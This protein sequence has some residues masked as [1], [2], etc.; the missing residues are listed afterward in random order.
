[1]SKFVPSHNVFSRTSSSRLFLCIYFPEWS[2]DVTRRKLAATTSPD[3]SAS[4]KTTGDSKTSAKIPI[5]LTTTTM[6]Q[7]VVARACKYSQRLGVRE[8]MSLSLARALVPS[9][10]YYEQFDPVRDAHALRTLAVW[11]LRFSPIVGLDNEIS[12]RILTPSRHPELA[13]VTAIHYGIIIDITGTQRVN[14]D[15]ETLCSKL[16]SLLSGTARIAIAPSLGGAWALS[17][18]SVSTPS[19]ALS[20]ESLTALSATLPVRA[21]RIDLAT[22]DKLSDVGVYTIGDLARLPRSSLGHRFGKALLCRLAQLSGTVSEQIQVVTPALQY[23]EHATFEPPLTHRRAIIRALEQLFTRLITELAHAHS[24]AA[25]FKI[26]ISDT[27][28]ASTGATVQKALALASATS[29]PSHLQAIIYPII[30]SMRFCG[31][32]RSV[33][34]E[35]LDTTRLSQAQHSFCGEESQ[36]P[37][38]RN[39]AYNELLNSLIVRLGRQRVSKA[40]ITQSYIPERSFDYTPE[41]ATDRLSSLRS[42]CEAAPSYRSSY[43]PSTTYSNLSLYTTPFERPPLLLSPPEPIISIAMLPDKAPSWIR[44]RG[45]KLSIISG[46]GPERIAPEW[47]RSALASQST[48]LTNS[49]AGSDMTQISLSQEP[50]SCSLAAAAA[51]RDYFTVQDESGRWLWVFR[52]QSSLKWFVH[53]VWR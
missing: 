23:R 49:C 25:L 50:L 45:A 21:L 40:T 52:C 53:G 38:S 29:D 26:S 36:D 24:A 44:W 34:I 28:G 12:Q 15:P 18:Y 19:I 10:T 17:R 46:L 35:A 20:H 16:L 30:E 33:T 3:T 1:M 37:L 9:N 2:I 31:E 11:C 14:G 48:A 42:L 32:V 7:Q 8:M 51:A 39:R 27:D 6:N 13:A 41:L 4:A 47:W 22:C 43:P 5:L